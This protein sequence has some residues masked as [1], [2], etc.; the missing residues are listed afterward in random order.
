MTPTPEFASFWREMRAIMY[1]PL[2][3]WL[4]TGSLGDR[5]LTDQYVMLK[6]TES[7]EFREL[8]DGAYKIA[9]IS[10]GPEP[11]DAPIDFQIDA[12]LQR[13]EERYW[14]SATPTPW[15]VDESPNSRAML[16]D[17]GGSPVL[18]G[19]ET[20]QAIQR[21]YPDCVPQCATWQDAEGVTH[22]LF[23]FQQEHTVNGLTMHVDGSITGTPYGEGEVA[24]RP[25]ETFAYAAGI[26]MPEG[27]G[28]AARMIVR[29]EVVAA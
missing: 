21:H 11:R 19:R 3:V 26:R 12:Y 2:E 13:A 15:S 7:E 8:P 6:V 1:Q 4:A 22:T 16:W 14:V 10:K 29:P 24:F 28:L 23:R 5:W 17:A 20:W 9:Y 25:P 18:L 27:A